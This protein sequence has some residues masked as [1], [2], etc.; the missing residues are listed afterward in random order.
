MSPEWREIKRT[1]TIDPDDVRHQPAPVACIPVRWKLQELTNT[2]YARSG[3]RILCAIDY[4]TPRWDESRGRHQGVGLG[5]LPQQVARRHAVC[6]QK[7]CLHSPAICGMPLPQICMDVVSR[8]QPIYSTVSVLPG[9][10]K[11]VNAL[12]REGAHI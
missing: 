5:G 2:L 3:S 12:P 7:S 10:R 4:G 8:M 6:W 1:R 9:L 11:I